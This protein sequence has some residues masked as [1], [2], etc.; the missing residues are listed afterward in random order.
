MTKSITLVVLKSKMSG[1]FFKFIEYS[2]DGWGKLED[3]VSWP[4]E[5]S[6]DTP[7]MY[8]KGILERRELPELLEHIPSDVEEVPI[9]LILGD[10]NAA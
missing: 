7:A 3:T 8:P 2:E 9:T 4:F 5:D 10:D 1:R 6:Y